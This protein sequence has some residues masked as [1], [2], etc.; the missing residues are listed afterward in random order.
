VPVDAGPAD[1]GDG[2]LRFQRF[3]AYGLVRDPAE[4]VLLTL[5]AT[6]YPGAGRWHLPGGGT[7]FGENAADGL[8]R[9]ILEESDQRAR[10]TGVLAVSHR[11]HDHAL[12]PEGVPIDWHGVRVIFAARVDEPT[13]P[14]VVE[15]AGSTEAAGWFTP[16]RADR[17]ALTEVARDVIRIYAL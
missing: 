5:I 17:L 12:G 10:I 6:G 7:D 9:E 8:L 15:R 11:R 2:T 1:V 13:P 3:A 4:R 14:V 16:E